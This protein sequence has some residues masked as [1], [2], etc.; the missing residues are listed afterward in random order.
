MYIPRVLGGALVVAALASAGPAAFA[1]AGPR[2][3]AGACSAEAADPRRY[4]A[5]RVRA[6]P[7]EQRSPLLPPRRPRRSRRRSRSPARTPS[8]SRCSRT[9]RRIQ[10]DLYANLN[11]DKILLGATPLKY[12]REINTVWVDFPQPLKAGREYA[13]D[14]HYSGNPKEQGRFGG[15]AYRKDPAGKDWIFTACEGEGAAVWWPNKDQWRDEVEKME[16]SVAIP[17]G[18]TDVS[19]GKF[20][21]QDRPR[22]RLHP[23]GLARA[24]PDQ[25]L[26]RVG[27]H[28]QLRPLRGPARQISRSTSTCCPA[29]SR[30]RSASS[31]RP[32][33]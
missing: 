17:N 15:M 31:R 7:G 18:L 8:A 1:G 33:R 30:G 23:L 4:P 27:E 22:R 13:I 32:S 28:R 25:Q 16:I 19:N 2:F 26:Q 9:T 24:V 20:A 21:R 5:R 3:P 12:E 11:V 6:L 10:L 29:A 14:F